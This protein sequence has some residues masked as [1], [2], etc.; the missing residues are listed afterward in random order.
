MDPTICLTSLVT[1][2]LTDLVAEVEW[3]QHV[4]LMETEEKSVKNA[5][6]QF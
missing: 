4:N 6:Q 5:Y 1:Y 2:K 3:Y